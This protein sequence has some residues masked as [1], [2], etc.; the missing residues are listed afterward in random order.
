MVPRLPEGV[1]PSQHLVS[2]LAPSGT[3]GGIHFYCFKP[4]GLLSGV[5]ANADP[6]PPSPHLTGVAA[7]VP[8]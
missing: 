4:S 3:L 6:A 7:Q 1:W 5:G 8:T 2:I